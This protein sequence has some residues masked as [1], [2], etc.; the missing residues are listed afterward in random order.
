ML[1]WLIAV[2]MQWWVALFF[3][4]VAMLIFYGLTRIVAEAGLGSA[5]PP[6]LAPAFTISKLG[7]RAMSESSVVA[8][9]LQYPYAVDV[10]AFVMAGAAN[11]LKL[12]HEIERR[13]RRLFFALVAA[14]LLTL[15]IS[16]AT[17]IYMSYVYQGTSLEL[18]YYRDAPSYGFNYAKA[19][20][21]KTTNGLRAGPNTLGWVYSA[22][23][24][25]LMSLLMIAQ[26][27]FLRWPIHPIGLAIAGTWVMNKLWFSVFLAWL[28]KSLV[29]KYGGPRLYMRTIAFFL[30][31]VIGQCVAAGAGCLVDYV[32]GVVG[33]DVFTL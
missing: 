23:G 26:R 5:V 10:R 12:T 33:N 18:W 6:G 8:L 15:L 17:V 1:G 22:I 25:V 28:I 19:I 24:V 21:S 20:L 11:G 14:V 29:L 2:G 32:T 9:G 16:V 13:R 3:W 27:R 7:A 31:M 4:T 30:G